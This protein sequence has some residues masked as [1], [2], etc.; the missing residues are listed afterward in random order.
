MFK[1]HGY[2]DKRIDFAQSPVSDA[3]RFAESL[4]GL[5][6]DGSQSVTLADVDNDGD[7]DLVVANSAADEIVVLLN[8]AL[9]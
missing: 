1:G 2:R 5:E 6:G 8:R 7:A 9:P 3:A 4:Y